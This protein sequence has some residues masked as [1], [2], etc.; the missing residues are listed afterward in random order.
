VLLLLLLPR[1]L[2]LQYLLLRP[3]V[4]KRIHWLVLIHFKTHDKTAGTNSLQ[5]AGVGNPESPLLGLP[6]NVPLTWE[7]PVGC[8]VT[9]MHYW[10][11]QCSTFVCTKV[12]TQVTNMYCDDSVCHREMKFDT[13]AGVHEANYAIE[14]FQ[15]FKGEW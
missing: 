12:R 5:D 1:L 9:L 8:D 6:D 10:H 15:K 2:C 11:S 3:L 7:E 4:K 13:G 14:S